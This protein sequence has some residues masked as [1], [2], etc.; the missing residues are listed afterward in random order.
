MKMSREN[1]NLAC[2]YEKKDGKLLDCDSPFAL[3][4]AKSGKD[5]ASEEKDSEKED[6]AVETREQEEEAD[7]EV[8]DHEGRISWTVLC[9]MEGSCKRQLQ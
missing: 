1:Q 7:F 8:S 4:E 6:E 9:R 3:T 2:L 5:P